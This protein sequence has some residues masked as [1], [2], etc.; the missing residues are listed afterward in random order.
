MKDHFGV[1][2]ARRWRA[3]TALA[4]ALL[5]VGLA[6]R[7]AHPLDKPPKVLVLGTPE[8][9]ASPPPGALPSEAE[10]AKAAGAQGVPVAQASFVETRVDVRPP[11]GDWQ[12]LPEGERVRT[13]DRLRTGPESVARLEFPWMS[14]SLAPASE[15][16]VSKGTILG[17]RL[18]AGRAEMASGRDEMIKLDTPEARLRGRG[19]MVVRRDGST[20]RVSVL[21]GDVEVRGGRG[22]ARL[23]EGFGCVV[24]P[25]G[26]CVPEPL[27]EAPTGLSPG[28]DPLYV[29]VGERVTLTW[30]A[31]ATTLHVQVL[32]FDDDTLLLQRDVTGPSFDLSLPWPGLYRWRVSARGTQGLEGP[33]SLEGLVQVMPIDWLKAGTAPPRNE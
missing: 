30:H 11:G 21:R 22:D 13:G 10:Q 4:L 7:D 19:Q 5:A 3:A 18:D 9:P 32:S 31:G 20:T 28:S 15:M 17:L 2:E 23:V 14:V 12:R 16:E 29:A 1:D 25:R 33:P 8:P 24:Q 26:A 27:P 6:A